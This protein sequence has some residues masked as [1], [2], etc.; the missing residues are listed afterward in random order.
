M[1]GAMFEPLGIRPDRLRQDRILDEARHTADPV[2]LVRVFG[3]TEYTVINYVHAAHR[4]RRGDDHVS[5]LVEQ[6]I[7][8]T[9]DPFPA[10]QP[11]HDD[12]RLGHLADLRGQLQQPHLSR[13]IPVTGV[14]PA[15]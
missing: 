12:E 13:D 2:H 11:V 15:T 1:I 8:S 9:A 14:Q 4:R 5:E 6:V 7:A 10:V 3:I